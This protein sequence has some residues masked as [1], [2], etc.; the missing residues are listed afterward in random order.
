VS[1]H[2]KQLVN[3]GIIDREQRSSYAYF[4]IAPG[5]IERVRRRLEPPALAA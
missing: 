1:Y 2:I 4:S 3:A 5:A